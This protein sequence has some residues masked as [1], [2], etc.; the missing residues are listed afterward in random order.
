MRRDFRPETKKKMLKYIEEM[1]DDTL[2][3]AVKDFIGDLL[4]E[5]KHFFKYTL[6]GSK[7]NTEDELNKYHK[8]VVDKADALAEE[9]NTIFEMANEEDGN[10]AARAALLNQSGQELLS[11]LKQYTG[12]ATPGGIVAILS[13]PGVGGVDGVDVAIVTQEPEISDVELA[14]FSQTASTHEYYKSIQNVQDAV[15]GMDLEMALQIAFVNRHEILVNLLLSGDRGEDLRRA[16]RQM[17]LDGENGLIIPVTEIAEKLGVSVGIVKYVIANGGLNRFARDLPTG[18]SETDFYAELKKYADV[19]KCFKTI[20]ND[21]QLFKK[22]C[23]ELGVNKKTVDAILEGNVNEYSVKLYKESIMK[24]L[25]DVCGKMEIKLFP[26]TKKILSGLNDSYKLMT[27]GDQSKVLK[28]IWSD[29]DISPEEATEFLQKYCGIKNVSDSHIKALKNITGTMNTS[30]EI[31]GYIK[32]GQQAIDMLDYWFSDYTGEMEMLDRLIA[33]NSDDPEYVLA[34]TDIK[35]EY[36]NRFN[37][38]VEKACELIAE[39]GISAVEDFTPLGIVDLVAEKTGIKDTVDAAEKIVAYSSICPETVE[40]YG[41]AL[42]A[43]KTAPTDENAL[44]QVRSTFSMMKQTLTDYYDAQTEYAEHTKDSRSYQ[45]YLSYQKN[46]IENLRLGDDF[47]AI[48]YET[49]MEKYGGN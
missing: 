42:E 39:K 2:W 25:Q 29:G 34:L 44:T 7:P 43:L 19:D 46:K 4:L 40:A 8:E 30:K 22:F 38:T 47:T 5:I 17:M 26:D 1:K 33:A 9:V 45:A 15:L 3:G 20:M 12:M 18:M 6:F 16:V 49:F 41:K 32:K 23:D 37:G 10:F 14:A 27:A 28:D 31:S 48:S 11:V 24:S 13:P 35:E 21:E 36:T